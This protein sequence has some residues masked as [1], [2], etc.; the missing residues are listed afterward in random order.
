MLNLPIMI[1]SIVSLPIRQHLRIRVA[2]LQEMRPQSTNERLDHDLETRT[3]DV[4]VEQPHN[5]IVE[6]PKVAEPELGDEKD[7]ERRAD[8]EDAG[9]CAAQDWRDF[10][11]CNGRIGEDPIGIEE[12][13]AVIGR[14]E[15]IE[16]FDI[17]KDDANMRK[18]HARQARLLQ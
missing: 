13:E 12:E 8:A 18:L 15:F 7:D 10:R 9:G 6:T 11:V 14:P 2:S 4:G 17:S 5:G 1:D 3:G 16:L